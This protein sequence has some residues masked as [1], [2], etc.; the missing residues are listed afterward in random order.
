MTLSE[1]HE[2]LMTWATAEP[3]KPELLAA[4]AQHFEAYGEPHEEDRTYEARQNGMLDFY[5]YDY[6]HGDTGG[7]MLE[8]FLEAEGGTLAPEAA[9]AYHDLG[10]TVHAL[11]EVR[12]I[13]EGAVRVRDV[14][15]GGDYDVTERRTVAG[16]SKGDLIEARLIPWNGMLFFS[17]AF[18]YHP[19]EVR[20]L[21][22]AEV[23]KR[24]KAAGKDGQVDVRG[25]LAQLSRMAFKMERYRN[26][27]IESI[28][29]FDAQDSRVGIPRPK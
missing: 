10:R 19:P 11:F 14:F 27:R 2:R 25:F 22:L 26:V 6:R 15:T 13:Q 20:K 18:L 3:R 9:A 5:L 29:D 7:T 1:L 28:Y 4:R 12:K 17:G 24:R 8:R 16:L 23:K 21:V